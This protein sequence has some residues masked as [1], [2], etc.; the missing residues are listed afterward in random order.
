MSNPNDPRFQGQQPAPAPSAPAQNPGGLH[1]LEGLGQLALAGAH[2]LGV[3]D[4]NEEGQAEESRPG[5]RRNNRFS[6][7]FGRPTKPTGSCC[8]AKRPTK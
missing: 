3:G 7:A 8:R 6:Q 5:R 2:F 1:F 4:D